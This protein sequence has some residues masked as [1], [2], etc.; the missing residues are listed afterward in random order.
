[1]T[2]ELSEKRKMPPFFDKITE[3]RPYWVYKYRF[4]LQKG[5][6]IQKYFFIFEKYD[7]SAF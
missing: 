5:I 6:K 3:N 7:V 1:M 2:K 4:T